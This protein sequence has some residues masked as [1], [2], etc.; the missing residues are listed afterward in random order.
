M[1]YAGRS[2]MSDGR[3]DFVYSVPGQAHDYLDATAG[4]GT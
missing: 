4:A 3:P 1:G 2:H